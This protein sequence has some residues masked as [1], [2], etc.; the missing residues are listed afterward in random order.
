MHPLMNKAGHRLITPTY[1]GLGERT[2]LANPPSGSIQSDRS[3]RYASNEYRAALAAADITAL[4]IARP[5]ATTI[6]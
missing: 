5:T 4:I 2:H 6:P 1:T 3:V